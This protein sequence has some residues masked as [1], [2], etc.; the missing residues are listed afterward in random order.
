MTP[1]VI[2]APSPNHGDRR[3]VRP[4]LVVLHYTAMATA[5]AALA[6]LCDPGPEVSAHW[7]IAEDGR[8]W[9]LVP[10]DRRAWHAGAGAWG[11]CADVNSASV[12]VELANGGD[13]PFP[14]PQ[15][16]ALEAVLRGTLD[17]WGIPPAGVI[18]HACMAPLR[19]QDPGR[20]F[21]WR[22]LARAG[23]CLWRAGPGVSGKGA[24]T[25][26]RPHPDRADSRTTQRVCRRAHEA[27]IL[28][29]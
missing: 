12:G 26:P 28:T 4:S 13:A 25:S 23:L 5:E 16:R 7:L 9:R 15:M 18:G 8:V 19:K 6:R 27:G 2:D 21:D 24:N 1:E 20:R 14:A 3:G 22:A 17:R 10:E 29:V 11:G